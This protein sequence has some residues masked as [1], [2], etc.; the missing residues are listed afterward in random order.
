MHSFTIDVY[1]HNFAVTHFSR[2]VKELLVKFAER[3]AEYEFIRK[4]DGSV[5]RKDNRYFIAA[6]KDRK[7]FRFHINSFSGFLDYLRR[8]GYTEKNINIVTH[9]AYTPLHCDFVVKPTHTPYEEQI[10]HIDY[11]AGP[12][13]STVTTLQTGKGKT[14]CAIVAMARL[15]VR[16]LIVLKPMY[17]DR[18]LQD[19]S[20][21]DS[22]LVG[23]KDD[24]MLVKSFRDLADLIELALMDAL[25]AKMIVI[26]NTIMRMYFDN[27][28]LL[29]RDTSL[30]HGV[31]PVDFYR[32]LRIGFRI[33]DE[34]HQDFHLNF[35]MD[36]Y[37]HGC[38]TCAL[39]ATLD[40]DKAFTNAMYEIMFP[41]SLRC[42]AGAY[43]KYIGCS[44]LLYHLN[45]RNSIKF[46][47]RGRQSYSHVAF[48]SSV[49]K[50]GNLT[51]N[52][53]HMI[54]SVVNERYIR[55]AVPGQRMIIFAA[56]VE[57][58]V[59]IVNDLKQR[60][61]SKIITKYTEE[62]Q[63][64]VLNSSDII[65]STLMSAGTAVDIK[66][67]RVVLV[68]TAIGSR[69]ANLQALGRLRELRDYPDVV[70]E[71]YYFVCLDIRSHVDY[72]ERKRESFKGKVL[73]HKN[74]NLG[75]SL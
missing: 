64:E 55:V 31:S 10:P 44:A 61:P 46:K 54:N 18:W 30:F 25:D 38:K 29:N 45:D 73:Y 24:L 2:D 62:D 3:F 39:S 68:T 52:Y 16:T 72:H 47:Q 69:Q 49:L 4:W 40:S 35:R 60:Y 74:V 57:M 8:F 36:L 75:L 71:F 20:G 17:L 58:C 67:L 26:S 50:R 14:S 13:L 22:I 59:V 21:K 15:S 33:V 41:P 70:P 56:S 12:Q 48:E 6:T 27:Y 53:L 1:T 19:L 51:R 9:E 42:N 11:I 63:Y 34:I 32:V 5:D 43:H 7:E 28:E 37:T 65:V 66:G 23:H